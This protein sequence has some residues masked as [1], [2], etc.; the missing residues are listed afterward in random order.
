MATRLNGPKADGKQLTINFVFKDVGETIVV[1][2]ENAV[3]HH[4]EA[5]ADPGADATV[6]LTRAFWLK[7]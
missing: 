1:R 2:V 7:R 5:A 6:T 4:K 3:L